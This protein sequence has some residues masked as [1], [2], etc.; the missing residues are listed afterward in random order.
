MRVARGRPRS[1]AR[2]LAPVSLRPYLHRADGVEEEDATAGQR[3][4]T[5]IATLP[6]A[7][8]ARLAVW[9]WVRG[10]EAPRALAMSYCTRLQE[11]QDRH[12]RY[13]GG[14]AAPDRGM[15][16]GAGTQAGRA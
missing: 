14:S 1:W 11:P 16:R 3:S 15:R 4:P 8:V 2:H 6:A 9:H 13:P 12:R 7:G 10:A 5:A